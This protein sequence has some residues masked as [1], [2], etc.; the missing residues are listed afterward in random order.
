M[1]LLLSACAL[2]GLSAC[3]P[4]NEAEEPDLAADTAS[5]PNTDIFVAEMAF[6]DDGLQLLNMR[7]ATASPGYDN[8]PSFVSG[9]HSFYFVSENDRSKTDIWVYDLERDEKRLFHGSPN[10]SEYSPKATPDG[11][12]ISYIQENE[13]GDVTRVHHAPVTGGAGEPVIELEPLGYYAW[14]AG[15]A[16]LGVYL[17][18]EPAMLH[19]VDVESGQSESIA[20]NIGRSFHATPDG[21]GLYFTRMDAEENHRVMYLD[22]DTGDVTGVVGLPAGRQDFVVVFAGADKVGGLLAGDGSTLLFNALENEMPE[23]R[24]VGDYSADGLKTITRIAI[25][26]DHAFIALVGEIE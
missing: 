21:Q 4:S 5:L 24:A 16:R 11:L 22:L 3:A 17:R 18:S 15:G 10:V 8:Q 26:D 25:S 7:N 12:S 23:W 1:R 14:L 2:F 19:L 6:G 9:T 13:T 20:D